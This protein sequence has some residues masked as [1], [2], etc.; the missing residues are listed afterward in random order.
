MNTTIPTIKHQVLLSKWADL[1]KSCQTSG[2]TVQNWCAQNNI[3][4]K[5]YYY[6]LKRVREQAIQNLPQADS[7]TQIAT[8]QQ[9]SL[10]REPEGDIT[11]KQLE[12]QSP[13]QGMQAAVIIKLPQAS[14]EVANDATQRTLEAVLLALKSVC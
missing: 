12:V 8:R 10:V 11:F 9:K 6:W 3:N 7:C 14:I 1:I 5:T 2:M 13:I 4:A